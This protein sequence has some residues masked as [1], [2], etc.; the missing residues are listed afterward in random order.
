MRKTLFTLLTVVVAAGALHAKMVRFAVIG[1]RTGGHVEG[2]YGRVVAEVEALKPEFCITVG[3][4]IEGY[5]DDTARLRAEWAEYDSIVAPLSCP[6]YLVPGNHDITMDAMLPAWQNRAGEPYYSFDRS[7]LH[8]VV[9]DNSRWESGPG[10]PAE[11]L[12]WL[13]KD[14]ARSRKAEHRI[15]FMHKPFWYELAAHGKPDTLHALFRHYGV[16]AVFTGHYHQ[17]FSGKLDG[18][19]YTVVGSSGGGTQPGPT[20]IEYLYIWVTVDDQGVHPVPVKLGAV[21]D[22]EEVSVN[23]ML[24]LERIELGGMR[25]RQPVLLAD[26]ATGPQPVVVDIENLVP[27]TEIS[28]TLRWTVPE[29]WTVEPEWAAVRTAAGETT[30]LEFSATLKGSP[31]PV[32]QAKLRF[33][34]AAGKD[35]PIEKLMR[36]ARTARCPRAEAGPAIDGSVSEQCWVGPVTRLYDQQGGLSLAEST[37]FYFCHDDANL[38]LGA[39]CRDQVPDSMSVNAEE[40]DAGVY[41]DDCV[42]YFLQPDT[43]QGI[44]YQIYFNP[45]GT[46]F[47]QRIRFDQEAADSDVSWNGEY[48]VATARGEGRWSIEVRVPFSQLGVET[49]GACWRTNFRRKQP[50][51]GNGDW[52]V[53]ISYDPATYGYLVFE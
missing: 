28:D 48:E 36:V 26:S 37:E 16:E 22:R 14:L 21:L 35:Y 24:T 30:A 31:F 45:A 25:V 11:Q 18:I 20:G 12:E 43:A 4:Q 2:I 40:R 10:L 6:L 29:G 27:G 23:D 34:Y 1:D 15:V 39:V 46:A 5:T 44:V 33:P 9:L 17:Y 19:T 41:A 38:Y 42:G 50:R 47:D 53:P 51:L 7:G 52:Q 3:D 49:A 8:V 32:P 13:D